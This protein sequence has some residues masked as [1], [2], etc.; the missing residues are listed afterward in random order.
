MANVY[1]LEGTFPRNDVNNPVNRGYTT[2]V[3]RNT[4]LTKL[5]NKNIFSETKKKHLA[6]LQKYPGAPVICL[7][8]GDTTEPIPEVI[9]S[10]ME[11]RAHNLS[12]PDGYTGYQLGQGDETLRIAIAKTF[13]KGL[14]VDK[15]E[16]FISDGAKSN[17]ARL[18]IFV[19]LGAVVG[20]TGPFREDIQKYKRVVYMTCSPE[21]DFFPDLSS[22]PRTDII[23]FCSPNNP[24]GFAATRKQLEDL[25]TF[26]HTNGSIIMYDSAYSMYISGDEPK[27]I[28]EIPGAREVAIETGSFSKHAGFTGVRL[29]WTVV[30]KGLLYADGYPVI[31]DFSHVIGVS[32]GGVS[33]MAEA[34]GVACLS[35]SGIQA[36][37]AMVG[38]Y[39][40]NAKILLDTFVSL[41]FKAFGGR[42]SPYVWVQYP[43]KKSEEVF[44]E[45]LEKIHVLTVP[46][47]GFG[48]S[49]EGFLRFSGFGH[50]CDILE[51]ARRLRIMYAKP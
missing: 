11:Q 3:P 43:G 29:G 41:G 16:I 32:F 22:V 1:S 18:Q 37:E 44:D 50:R 9:T 10:A 42:D 34:G 45:I 30:P 27:S 39:K 14:G 25:V 49:G 31:K 35:P 46:G 21:N 28:Y 23:F 40:E 4:N 2:K 47:V 26:A 51:A 48:P 24:T 15:S 5:Q 8:L 19:A 36:M 6:H 13:Y 20:Q 38:F 17:I 12:R 33:N 7:G